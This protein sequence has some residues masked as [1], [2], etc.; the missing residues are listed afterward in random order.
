MVISGISCEG[1]AEL[2]GI[3][4]RLSQCGSELW[5]QQEPAS[6]CSGFGTCSRNCGG[7]RVCVCV[8]LCV[9]H[10]VYLLHLTVAVILGVFPGGVTTERQSHTPSPA[11]FSALLGGWAVPPP[12]EL[13]CYLAAQPGGRPRRCAGVAGSPTRFPLPRAGG[14]EGLDN[15]G[16]SHI[17]SPEACLIQTFSA[18]MNSV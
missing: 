3:G 2:L 8:C 13:S 5:A 16:I 9:S 6:Y 15:R 10:F 1:T 12:M 7:G 17:R 18:L 11:A 14:G 4:M